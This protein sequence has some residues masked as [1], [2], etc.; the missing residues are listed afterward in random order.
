[1][2]D[3]LICLG[4][5]F[6]SMGFGYL[7][8]EGDQGHYISAYESIENT[9]IFSAL[10]IYRSHL[11]TPEFGHFLIIWVFS[12]LLQVEKIVA[13]SVCNAVLAFVFIRWVRI[14]GGSVGLAYIIVITNFYFWVLYLSAERLK[15]GF[16]FFL[17]FLLVSAQ[18][19]KAFFFYAMAVFSHLQFIIFAASIIIKNGIIFVVRLFN[20]CLV[21][22]RL[23][24]YILLLSVAIWSF[25]VQVGDYLLWKIPQYFSSI[26]IDSIWQVTLFWG[27]SVIYSRR[28]L[29]SF[30]LFLP[31]LIA[32]IVV[33]PTRITIFAYFCFL[34][35][36]FQY[37]RGV[38]IWVALTSVY[39]MVKTVGF[40][41][42]VWSTGQGY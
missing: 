18:A 37:K 30:V 33:G 15:I 27:L 3:I 13:M 28:W 4:V 39:F 6:L 17:L 8:T 29:D 5:F 16:I 9:D 26:S 41:I 7:Y 10:P 11:A 14:L 1:M 25:F 42:N 31:L 19:K 35:Y 32:S 21:R 36:G 34:Y 2:S 20:T 23:L 12:S 22:R 40:L 38:N 24:G